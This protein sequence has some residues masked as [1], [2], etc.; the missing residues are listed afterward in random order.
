MKHTFLAAIAAAA[1]LGGACS[2]A[3]AGWSVQGTVADVDSAKI[4]LEGFN[5]GHWYVIDSLE[6]DQDGSFAY[7]ADAPAA[8]PDVM[9][10]S[11]NGRSIYFPVDSVGQVE[12]TTT[13]ADFGLRYTLAGSPDAAAIHSLDSLINASIE[14]VGVDSTLR[15]DALKQQLFATAFADQQSVMPLYYLINRSVGRKPLFDINHRADMRLY[16]A[17][18]QRFSILCPD[19]PRTAY[20]VQTYQQA[21][22]ARSGLTAEY[23]V[24]TASLPADIVRYDINGTEHSLAQVAS[25]GNVVL[26][27]FTSYDLESSPS[28]NALLNT[29]YEKHHA[30][31]L[32]IYQLAFDGDESM[33]KLR[34]KNLPWIAVW[35]TTTDGDAVLLSYNVGALPMTFI[36]DRN[37]TIAERVVDPTN[38]EKIVA[39]YL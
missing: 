1:L 17:V 26:L 22:A 8:Y 21:L 24:P 11:L 15:C 3:P 34:A 2:Q 35:N 38:L 9:R 16:G 39:K 31:G 20:M 25:K 36:I 32:E 13:A 4:I 29:I 27:S 6:V 28:Y 30:N 33:W 14:T 18:A 23:E 37:G 5:N 7:T 10:I 12:V 19:D